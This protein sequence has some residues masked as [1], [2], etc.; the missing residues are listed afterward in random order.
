MNKTIST[1]YNGVDVAQVLME[2]S[3]YAG[4]PFNVEPGALQ[5][6][7]PEFRT[8][9]LILENATIQQ[10]LE[11][12]ASVSRVNV[13]PVSSHY[14]VM[15]VIDVYGSADQRDLGSVRDAI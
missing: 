3:R 13:S 12:L 4:V 7:P 2:L 5:R 9:R 8:V 6:I 1:R 11:N 10:I 14:N 15:P